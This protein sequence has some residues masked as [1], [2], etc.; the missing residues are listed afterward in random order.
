MTNNEWDIGADLLQRVA[1][2]DEQAFTLIFNRYYPVLRPFVN[3]FTHSEADT[4]ERLQETF[5]RL[6]LSRDRLPEVENL[7][8][9]IFTIASRQCLKALRKNLH[10][11]N[12]ISAAGHLPVDREGLTP[13]DLLEVNDII[14]LVHQAVSQ[15]PPRRR[16]IFEMSRNEG[17]K[18]AEIAAALSLSVST[19]KNVL[20]SSLQHVREFLR[21]A[22]HV[23]PLVMISAAVF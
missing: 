22:G 20:T 21:S 6:W 11:R 14:N 17:M 9:W 23:L 19:V 3:S 7:K 18:P 4:E 10:E 13:Y 16:K 2:G 1:D 15:M 8:A 5:M 12:K